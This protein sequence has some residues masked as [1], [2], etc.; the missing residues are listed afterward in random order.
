MRNLKLP[1]LSLLFA[2]LA[3]C[4]LFG[5]E[6]PNTW[7]ERLSYAYTLETGA[8]NAIEAQSNSG[9]LTRDDANK[10]VDIV[11][12]AKA[13]TDGARDAMRGGDAT[14]AEGKLRLA[15]SILVEIN[16]YLGE[17]S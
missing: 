1:A 17:R 13:L 5:L 14:T 6:S 12:N 15:R 8:A 3:G 9:Q 4:A 7:N 11:Q 16:E 2:L 10:L